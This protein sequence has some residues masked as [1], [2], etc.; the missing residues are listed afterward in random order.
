MDDTTLY[1]NLMKNPQ[2]NNA[3]GRYN[4]LNS[5]QA[6]STN[7]MNF[8]QK[9][10]NSIGNALGTTGAALYESGFN[11]PKAAIAGLTG[12]NYTSWH[13]QQQLKK[14]EDIRKGGHQTIDDVY[15]QFGFNGRDD[16]D[17]Q[18]YAAEGSGNQAEADRLLN[19]PGLQK[20][21][22]DA[23]NGTASAMQKNINEYNDYRAN[24]AASKAINQDQGK[25]LGSAINTLSTGFDIA[26]TLAG[27]PNGALVNGLQ[28]GIEG[29]ADELEEN[30]FKDFDWGRAGLNMGAGLASGLATG[31][32][33]SGLEKRGITNMLGN[34]KVTQA[35]SRNSLGRTAMGVGNGAIRGALSGAV[36]GATGA[37]TQ[38]A[39]TGQDIEQ[40]LMNTL[41][42]ARQGALSGSVV[43]GSMGGFNSLPGV[44]NYINRNKD[45]WDKWTNS[46][47]NFT[48]RLYNTLDSG[49]GRV[50]R[51]LNGEPNKVLQGAGNLGN[52]IRNVADDN[53]KV[54][55][56]RQGF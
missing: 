44:S 30:G 10:A 53:Y 20:A 26:S 9:K 3:I 41:Q 39:L 14:T 31:A 51:W 11:L 35:L 46:G 40:G 6:G 54:K 4:G 16:Y 27:I 42:G 36:G 25:F 19:L 15:R 56:Y 29:I 52:R 43:G 55:P 48:D 49:E 38:S 17:N 24:N 37:A 33:N 32:L 2:A 5:A 7:P 34:N 23:A 13:D 28:G 12:G 47:D 45:A 18:L 8:F 21:L 1:Y 50:G 22:Q